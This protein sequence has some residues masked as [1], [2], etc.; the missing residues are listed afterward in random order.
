MIVLLLIILCITKKGLEDV[1]FSN[2]NLFIHCCRVFDGASFKRQIK[3]L[4]FSQAEM[5]AK[6]KGLPKILYY[7]QYGEK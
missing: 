7:A 4:S 1:L 3:I 6:Q 2:K 5:H